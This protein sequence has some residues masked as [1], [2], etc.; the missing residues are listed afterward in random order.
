MAIW[1]EIPAIVV[2]FILVDKNFQGICP[3]TVVDGLL[4]L[5]I[6]MTAEL[7]LPHISNR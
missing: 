1:D 7:L 4:L 6:T 2:D 5:A 3:F